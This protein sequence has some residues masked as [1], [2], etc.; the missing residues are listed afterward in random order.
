[1]IWFL[2]YDKSIGKESKEVFEYPEKGY[3]QRRSEEMDVTQLR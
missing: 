3:D 1:M 2:D